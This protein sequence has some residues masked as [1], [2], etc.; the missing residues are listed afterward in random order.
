MTHV[1]LI[2]Q[3]EDVSH[4]IIILKQYMHFDASTFK[5]ILMES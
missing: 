5:S 4:E 1:F 3:I 2:E